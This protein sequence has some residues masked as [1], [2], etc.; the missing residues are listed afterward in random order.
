MHVEI[1]LPRLSVSKSVLDSISF[2]LTQF[3]SSTAAHS[4]L[5][6]S[7][8][9]IYRRKN[10]DR[11]DAGS[12]NSDSSS[13]SGELF[14]D[15]EWFAKFEARGRG[16][17]F[18]NA[19]FGD[20]DNEVHP[21]FKTLVD[22]PGFQSALRL[23]SKHLEEPALLPFWH[24]LLCGG[25]QQLAE[26]TAAFGT[27]V[28]G[29]SAKLIPLTADEIRETK[30]VLLDA[31]S[32]VQFLIC[33]RAYDT[34]QKQDAYAET[35]RIQP[36]DRNF[37]HLNYNTPG[38][39]SLILL[40]FEYVTH[41]SED[42]PLEVESRLRLSLILARTLL[43]ELAHAMFNYR[44]PPIVEI[45]GRDATVE[46]FVENQIFSEIGMAMEVCL[47]GGAT[48][49]TCNPGQYDTPHGLHVKK[50]P[51]LDCKDDFRHYTP[52][53]LVELLRKRPHSR[54]TT[55]YVLPMEMIQKQ[56]TTEFWNTEVK[57]TGARALQIP[58]SPGNEFF[59]FR[60]FNNQWKAKNEENWSDNTSLYRYAD[61]DLFVQPGQTLS[62]NSP[63]FKH[64]ATKPVSPRS[65]SSVKGFT[66][67]DVFRPLAPRHA[68][69]IRYFDQH[70]NATKGTKEPS[71]TSAEKRHFCQV[72]Y[73]PV[74]TKNVHSIDLDKT[75][76]V[77]LDPRYYG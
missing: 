57:A 12:S 68:R 19:H 76:A 55:Y 33:R 1:P 8:I 43:H 14:K 16:I 21:I 17:N 53:G 50:Y 44:F 3:I 59:G 31:S 4:P 32:H 18:P 42:S 77:D 70:G 38:S 11:M 25:L 47:F 45:C 28:R 64:F 61:S 35:Y 51:S 71:C 13:G 22:Q 30:Q 15:K 29:M 36:N 2:M 58:K 24:A 41:L 23:A 20:L 65:P 46:P 6:L 63:R 67:G 72:A 40:L 60:H 62:P 34:G 48:G 74:F 39:G 49:I 26:E 56:F 7:R 75:A 27:T 52:Q 37:G 9:G 66:M 54:W 69:T 5:F 73:P 10:T